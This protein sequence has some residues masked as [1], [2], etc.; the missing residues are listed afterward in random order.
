MRRVKRAGAGLGRE[1]ELVTINGRHLIN[2]VI[3]LCAGIN[4]FERLPPL[5]PA[6]SVEAVIEVNPEAIVTTSNDASAAR[7][8][9]LDV[10]RRFSRLRATAQDNLIVL[11]AD[12]IHRSSPRILD[13]AAALCERLENVRTR[14]A[15]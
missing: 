15:P 6:V 1:V 3:S 12:M 9:G 13:G 10:W 14:G 8:D 7:E 11:D 4:I 5:V 2:D